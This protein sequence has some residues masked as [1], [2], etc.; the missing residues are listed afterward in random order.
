M[1]SDHF[2]FN[3]NDEPDDLRNLK[4]DTLK[5]QNE[6][7]KQ[8]S[9]L[10]EKLQLFYN[11]KINNQL[12]NDTEEVIINNLQAIYKNY[13]QFFNTK[14]QITPKKVASKTFHSKI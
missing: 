1:L 6:C 13:P 2:I 14:T 11:L 12:S 5:A 7:I 10:K 8:I 9:S 3:P 4:T